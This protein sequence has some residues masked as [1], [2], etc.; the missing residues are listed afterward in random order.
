MSLTSLF[1]A[2]PL[3]LIFSL[4]LAAPTPTTLPHV[5]EPAP[6]F[7]SF[8]PPVNSTTCAAGL[9]GIDTT[10]TLNNGCIFLTCNLRFCADENPL[11]LLYGPQACVESG[12]IDCDDVDNYF[13]CALDLV[14][15]CAGKESI[16]S[17]SNVAY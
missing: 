11:A 2:L 4:V 15:R 8:S 7:H 10:L 6:S 13:L 5:C 9:V 1:S 14:V 12:F 16:V 17:V 3:A